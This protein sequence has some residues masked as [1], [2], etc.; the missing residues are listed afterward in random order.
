MQYFLDMYKRYVDFSG[1]TTRK[2]FWCAY[3]IW[4]A[5]YAV[6]YLISSLVSGVN[7]AAVV[8][9][10]SA[11]V[12]GGVMSVIM[13]GVM[14]IFAL[15]SLI[16]MLAMEVRRLRDAGYEW[17]VL[18]LCIVGSCACGIGSIVL[19]ILLCMPTKEPENQ[20]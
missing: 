14:L 1:R 8:A 4:I 11:S 18:L 6:L 19:L 15:G 2:E 7:M 17:W 10:G 12:G 3:G 5:I 20:Y 9:G 16:P 13:A